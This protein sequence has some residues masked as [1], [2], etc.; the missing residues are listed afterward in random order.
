MP[1]DSQPWGVGT[2]DAAW[3]DLVSQG[4]KTMS[5]L[6]GYPPVTVEFGL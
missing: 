1:P 4:L 6:C 2:E 5:G 3:G